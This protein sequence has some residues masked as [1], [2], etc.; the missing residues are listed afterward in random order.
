MTIPRSHEQNVASTL[1]S[2]LSPPTGP[3]WI[4]SRCFSGTA[5]PDGRH[6]LAARLAADVR[7]GTSA[8]RVRWPPWSKTPPP[9]C[10]SCSTTSPRRRA[11]H[12]P[13]G[14][15][16]VGP[17]QEDPVPHRPRVLLIPPPTP[18]WRG[19]TWSTPGK[20]APSARYLGVMSDAAE[21][22]G[23]PPSTSTTSGP[24]RPAMSAQARPSGASVR[25]QGLGG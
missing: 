20:A 8:G 13:L 14:G 3:T 7:Q 5:L 19:F 21:V 23:A 2:C 15:H 10:S 6:R 18:F 1:L 9:A 4:P 25:G 24:A 12:G 22:A 16:G 11:E 17:A